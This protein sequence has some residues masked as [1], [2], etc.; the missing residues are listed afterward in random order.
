[1]PSP[2]PLSTTTRRLASVG[3]SVR[4]RGVRGT[5]AELGARLRPYLHLAEQHVWYERRLDGGHAD[6]EWPEGLRLVAGTADDL[7]ALDELDTVDAVEAAQRLG[8][9]A[10]WWL[11]YDGARPL[12]SCWLFTGET[13][14]LAAPGGRLRLPAD[15]V[16]ME[17]SVTSA[18]ARG[19]GIA[20]RA[21][22]ALAALSAAR[23]ERM[24]T[25][26]AVD[27]APSRRA[28]EKAGFEGVAIMSLR[29][30]G[31]WRQTTLQPLAAVPGWLAA[32]LGAA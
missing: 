19:R 1:M 8:A 6:V 24:L 10:Q 3:R 4:N 22:N 20:P 9:G 26:V 5:G 7:P 27:N 12:F 18:A 14:V 2:A 15:T 13:A 30:V 28:V 25:K 16:V 29:K 21:A 11:V 32:N 23:H 17:D 31:P